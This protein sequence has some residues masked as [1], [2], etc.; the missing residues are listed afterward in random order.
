[1]SSR[2]LWVLAA[3][4]AL[5]ACQQ[6][7]EAPVDPAPAARVVHGGSDRPDPLIFAFTPFIPQEELAQ[8]FHSLV[9]YVGSQLG[10][11]VEVRFAANYRE[12]LHW[13]VADEAHVYHLSP[14][15]YVYAKRAR[16]ELVILAAQIAA[17]SPSYSAY[18]VV[19]DDSPANALQDLENGVFGFVDRQSA[20]GYLYPLAYMRG[21]GLDVDTF[22]REVR[23]L[24]NHTAVV[25][26]VLSGELDAGATFSAVY[27]MAGRRRDAKRLRIL[28]KTGRIPYE[29]YC[30]TPR[31]DPEIIAQLRGLMVSLS[32]RTETGRRILRGMTNVNGFLGVG[33]EHYAEVRRMARLVEAVGTPL[34]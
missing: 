15:N 13:V 10:V 21:L 3:S 28:A 22:F 31:L 32:T 8:G 5:G 19:R 2:G 1:M 30:A 7:R 20:S 17:G 16:P 34:P 33:D 4:V 6:R 26:G 18:V 23:F 9:D 27:Q 29:A 12:L 14:L 11:G 25:D 24:G